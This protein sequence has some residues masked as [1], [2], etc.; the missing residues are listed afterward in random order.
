MLFTVFQLR[1]ESQNVIMSV[2]KDWMDGYYTMSNLSIAA[3][4]VED[5]FD[6]ECSWSQSVAQRLLNFRKNPK[7]LSEC[8]ICIECEHS[9]RT[10]MYNK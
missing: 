1:I 4:T 2:A 6:Y 10:N 5:S 3:S 8:F 9:L 7:V